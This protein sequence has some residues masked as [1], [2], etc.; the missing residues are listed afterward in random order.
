[1]ATTALEYLIIAKDQAS[2]T[3]DQI[4]DA[5]KRQ[6]SALETFSSG[7]QIALA[8]VSAAAVAGGIAS[9]NLASDLEETLSKSDVVFGDSADEMRAWAETADTAMGLSQEAA[10]ASAATFGDMFSQLGYVGDE[11]AAMSQDVVQLAADLGSFHNVDTG[12]VL[13]R[14]SASMRGEYDSLQQLIPNINA[15]RVQQEALAMTGKDAAD[16]LTAQEKVAATLAIIHED[17]ANAAGNFAATSD[18]LANSQRTLTAQVQNLGAEVGTLLLPAVTAVVGALSGMIGALTDTGSA[19]QIVVGV[20]GGLIG[21]LAAASAAAKVYTVWQG[22]SAV[23][24]GKQAA[25]TTLQTIALGVQKAATVTSTAVQW[26]FNAAL[27]ANPIGIVVLA[28]A[29]LVAALV[30]FFTQTEIGQ[31]IWQTLV[32]WF[33]IGWEWIVGAFQTGYEAVVDWLG[34]VWEFMQTVWSYSPLGMVVENWDAIVEFVTGL[35]GKIADAAT[36][37]W[38]G[39][40]SAFKGAVNALIDIWNNFELTIGGGSIAGVDLP[41]ITLATPNLPHLATGGTIARGG[42]ALVGERGPEIVTLPTG[43]TVHS[44]GS[45]MRLHPDDIKA[46]AVE[47]AHAAGDLSVST[48]E[49]AARAGQGMRITTG[50]LA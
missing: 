48:L 11:S 24:S 10:L 3:F 42:A 20:V 22:I 31:Q 35:P 13:D 33:Q 41:S 2:E 14:I 25:Q 36:G 27:S 17:G 37:M 23:L 43:A 47:M 49:R 29:A 18:G 50:R 38:D 40:T 19:G 6:Q 34:Q 12:D 39:I 26:A 16:E 46:L 5:A 15:A 4:G 21:V 28:I 30:Y 45:A 8:A 7:A 9:V 44:N 32:E 1:M